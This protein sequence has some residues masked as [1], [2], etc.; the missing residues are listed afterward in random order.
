MFSKLTKWISLKGTDRVLEARGRITAAIDRELEKLQ[1]FIRERLEAEK[2]VR[3]A[4]VAAALGEP[5]DTSAAYRRVEE[6]MKSI[7][8]QSSILVGLRL[9][10]AATVR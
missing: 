2:A 8:R 10:A 1:A 5:A 7:G 3:E 9:R 6:V 4:E